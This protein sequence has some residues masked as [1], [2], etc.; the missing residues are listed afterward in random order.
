MIRNGK[1]V[2]NWIEKRADGDAILRPWKIGILWLY[3][4]LGF[5]YLGNVITN[6]KKMH[7]ELE[8]HFASFGCLHKLAFLARSTL[9]VTLYN[10]NTIVQ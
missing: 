1:N 6:K 2:Q 9:G 3:L 8:F 7:R 10:V 5:E 4:A